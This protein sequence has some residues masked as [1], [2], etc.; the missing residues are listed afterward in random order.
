MGFVYLLKFDTAVAAFETRFNIPRD[1]QIEYCPRGNIEN[2][3]CPRVVFFPLMAILEG[4]DRFPVDPL[5]LRTLSFYRLSPDQCL[6]NFY[7]VLN[8]VRCLNELYNLG[9]NHHDINFLYGI[10]G[11]L[12]NGYYLK[13]QVPVAGLIQCLPTS[14]RN[15]TREFIKVSEN[16]LAGELTYPTS[17]RHISWNLIFL[18]I[19][20]AR[21]ITYVLCFLLFCSCIYFFF[22]FY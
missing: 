3:R 14:N 13:I 1:I 22:F 15:S 10:Y 8:S 20:S 7:K 6:P 12:K 21:L 17:L 19:S 18:S 9:L 2:D 4:G 5:L 16:W 11:S